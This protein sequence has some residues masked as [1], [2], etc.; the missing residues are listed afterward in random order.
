M[1]S[2]V[3][4]LAETCHLEGR[5]EASGI[6]TPASLVGATGSV[7]SERAVMLMLERGVLWGLFLTSWPTSTT[8]GS[9]KDSVRNLIFFFFNVHLFLRER[10]RDRESREGVKREGI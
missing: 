1:E 6:H 3:T 2:I 8:L 4:A 5:R 10:E 7:V 9:Y